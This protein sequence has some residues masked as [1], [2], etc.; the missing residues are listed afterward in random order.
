MRKNQSRL[1]CSQKA[2][3]TESQSSWCSFAISPLDVLVLCVFFKVWNCE[4]T[5]G[6]LLVLNSFLYFKLIIIPKHFSFCSSFT[7]T[8]SKT[9]QGRN[10][11]SVIIWGSVLCPRTLHNVEHVDRKSRASNHPV[12]SGRPALPA[13]PQLTVNRICYLPLWAECHSQLLHNK[14]IDA[15]AEDDF[16]H[17]N[18]ISFI[19][20]QSFSK[21]EILH[22]SALPFPLT[23]LTVRG[24]SLK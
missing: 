19:W 23:P 3:E 22:S 7:H 24:A 20:M 1:T 9:T 6:M 16:H 13:E 12:I 5:A 21:I 8:H 11:P 15:T 14:C 2:S 17:S 4:T 10:H 18:L